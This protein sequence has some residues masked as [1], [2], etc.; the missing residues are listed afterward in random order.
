MSAPATKL[1]A[2]Q[3]YRG[4]VLSYERAARF[5]AANKLNIDAAALEAKLGRARA[6]RD[7]KP[8]PAAATN[9]QAVHAPAG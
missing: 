4:A 2:E 7:G 8:I 5:A 6:G 9:P 1:F 3:S